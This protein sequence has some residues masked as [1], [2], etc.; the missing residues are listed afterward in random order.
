MGNKLAKPTAKS[1]KTMPPWLDQATAALTEDIIQTL[2]AQRPDALAII[3]YG[4]LARHDERP[5]TDAYPSDVDLLVVF[6]TED[7]QFSLLHGK[8]LFA[9]LGQV[10][11]RH[12]DT[13]RDVKVMFASRTLGEWD[14]TFV[15]SVARDGILL[16]ARGPL[17][18]A[19]VEVA[20]RPIVNTQHAQPDQRTDA[21]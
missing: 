13:R 14:S 3:L 8:A 1:V 10:Y 20:G 4:S 19:L 7:E 2:G 6:D 21:M 18:K 5:F 17:P 16:W 11:N 15:T 9:I 12:L